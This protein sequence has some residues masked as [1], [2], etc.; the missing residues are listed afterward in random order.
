[1][2]RTLSIL[3]LLVAIVALPFL[4]RKHDAAATGMTTM[5]PETP[6]AEPPTN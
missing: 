2:I 1:M 6:P 4:L 5:E 3:V